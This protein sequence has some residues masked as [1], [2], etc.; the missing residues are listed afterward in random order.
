MNQQL[1]AFF[2]TTDFVK[3][4]GSKAITE[5]RREER[6]SQVISSQFMSN[7]FGTG[8]DIITMRYKNKQSS[9]AQEYLKR[10]Y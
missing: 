4:H 3:N 9:H 5:E 2:I 7:L 10:M 6:F 1:S 8:H